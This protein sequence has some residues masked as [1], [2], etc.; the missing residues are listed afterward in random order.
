[1]DFEKIGCVSSV[2]NHKIAQLQPFMEDKIAV[3]EIPKQSCME[4]TMS[5][6]ADSSESNDVRFTGAIRLS[7]L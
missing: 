1:M 4:G 2:I 5:Q 6:F 3:V 7:C